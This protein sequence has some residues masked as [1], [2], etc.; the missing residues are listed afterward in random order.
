MLNGSSEECETILEYELF[1]THI[2]FR[3]H[4]RHLVGVAEFSTTEGRFYDDAPPGVGRHLVETADFSLLENAV[5]ATTLGLA[6]ER[7]T[8]GAATK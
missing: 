7:R 6:S 2:Y 8:I 4:G 1:P 3:V 5:S